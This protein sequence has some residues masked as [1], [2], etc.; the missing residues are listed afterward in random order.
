MLFLLHLQTI[1]ADGRGERKRRYEIEEKNIAK[2][3]I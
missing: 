3:R 2:I 1:L